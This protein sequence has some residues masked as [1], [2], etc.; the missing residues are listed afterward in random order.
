MAWIVA[1]FGIASPVAWAEPDFAKLFEGRDGCFLLYDLKTDKIV[2][3]AGDKR[4]AERVSPCSTFK[5]PLALAALDQ[6]VLED[7]GSSLKWDGKD[8]GREVWN[9]DQTTASWMKNSVVW[10][11]QRLTPKLGMRKLER[12]LAKMEY[13]NQDMTGGLTKAWL[14]STLKI[15][16]DEQLR[17]WRRFW[18][19]ELPLRKRAYAVTK[20]VMLVETSP[21][22]WTLHGKTGS[23][24]AGAVESKELWMGWFVGHVASGEREYLVVTSYTDR[25]PT[26]D[27][28]PPGWVAR[29]LTKQVLAELGLY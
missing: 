9:G 16:P 22:G 20:K 13:G 29:D 8:Y 11:S 10:F 5:V 26:T 12:Y 2:L 4:C 28:R 23:G 15:S 6:G 17:F 27:S 7:E 25:V 19:E 24:K 14:G 3:R 21:G 18:R 1:A